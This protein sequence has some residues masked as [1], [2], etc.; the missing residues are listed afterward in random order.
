M[1]RLRKFTGLAALLAVGLTISGCDIGGEVEAQQ[2]PQSAVEMFALPDVPIAS[3][4][5]DTDTEKLPVKQGLIY[6]VDI[7]SN[8]SKMEIGFSDI[9]RISY[10]NGT[11]IDNRKD[12]QD[13][14][15]AAYND[16][17]PDGWTKYGK[18]K[19]CKK[20]D[21]VVD[22]GPQTCPEADADLS[23]SNN[24]ISLVAFV[25]KKKSKNGNPKG[26]ITWRFVEEDTQ[27]PD[28]S[29]DDHIIKRHKSTGE[30]YTYL[31]KM[32]KDGKFKDA[33]CLDDACDKK[34]LKQPNVV[35]GYFVADGVAA[36]KAATTRN[37]SNPQYLDR[38]NLYTEIHSTDDT[39]TNI[40]VI[41]DP[42]V[43]WPGGDGP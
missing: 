17:N 43:R 23:I 21:D 27:T 4:D 37:S 7:D 34:K 41:I 30:Y 24:K 11:V 26:E 38:F 31:R 1:T 42:D 8:G 32:D 10:S 36:Y 25:L 5:G 3:A 40:P 35:G 9:Y 15:K 13:A 16:K 29:Q 22:G 19:R 28:Q 33:V 18:S 6:V 12:F 2:E 20:K 39:K 14:M